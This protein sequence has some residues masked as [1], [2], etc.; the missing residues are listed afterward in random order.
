MRRFLPLLL[1]AGCDS[2]A[3]Q[4]PGAAPGAQ[5]PA[6]QAGPPLPA[7]GS[8][9][10]SQL[11]ERAKTSLRAII[12]DPGSMR[13]A[14]LRAGASGS[15]CGDVDAKQ[16][17]G[18]K[19][20]RPFVVTPEGVAVVSTTAQVKVDDPEDPFPDFYIRWCASP[21]ELARLQPNMV[22]GETLGLGAPPPDIPDV[23]TDVPAA[24]PAPAP[25]P[26]RETPPAQA[27][28]EAPSR[29]P[30]PTSD[31][32]FFNAVARPGSKDGQ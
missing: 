2:Q 21:E 29:P 31:D 23:P 24:L 30:A 5:A 14:N 11:G 16:A 19:A 25:E 13:F 32:S 6:A 20:V 26:A 9:S 15:V 8:A 27:K 18:Q 12:A 1:L 4:D 7:D 22:G 10:A 3:D 17:D 28:A